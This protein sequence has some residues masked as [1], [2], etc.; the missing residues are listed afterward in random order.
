MINQGLARTAFDQL[1]L[2]AMGAA[3]GQLCARWGDARPTHVDAAMALTSTSPW[4]AMVGGVVVWTEHGAPDLSDAAGIPLG[5]PIAV[6]RIHPHSALRLQRL[7]AARFSTD[8]TTR[9]RPTPY[10]IAI[11]G[12]TP[13]P[14][15]TDVAEG[16]SLPPD[17]VV[18]GEPITEG[19][20]TFHDE[21]GLVIDPI[22]VANLLQDLLRGLPALRHTG[23][24][25]A[26]DV[27]TATPG[28]IAEVAG[29][30]IGRRLHL[31]D[32]WGRPWKDT[33]GREGVRLG[34]GSR[35]GAGPHDWDQ[36][37]SVT[38][39]SGVVRIG[40]LPDGTLATASLTP[41]ALPTATV[42][43][44]AATAPALAREFFRVAVV[45]LGLHLTGNR[46]D[47]V[48]D[49]VPGADAA[50]RSEPAPPLGSGDVEVATNGQHLLG[51]AAEIARLAGTRL[52][53]APTIADDVAVP[54]SRTE[55]WPDVPAAVGTPQD[56]TGDNTTRARADVTAAYAADTTDVVVTWPDGALP[57]ESFV[58]VFP[59]V[60]PGPAIVPLSE[61]RFSRRGD[62]GAGVV[63]GGSDFSLLVPDPF[64]VGDGTRPV[65]PTLILDLLVVT[66]GPGGVTGRLLGSITTDVAAD[67][68]APA[69]PPVTNDFDG[70]ADNA[71]GIAPAPVLG[72]PQTATPD[73]A[74]PILSALGEAAPREAPRFATMA[75]TDL[76]AAGHDGAAPGAWT[77]VVGAGFLAGRSVRGDARLGN[78]GLRAGPEDHAP[79]LRAT[80][81]L[82]QDLA[83]QA[84]RRTHHLSLRLAELNDG[85]WNPVSAV[86]GNATGAVLQSIAPTVEAPE[87]KVVPDSVVNA[88]PDDWDGLIAALAGLLPG[89]MSGLASSI[90]DPDAGDRWVEEVRRELRAV[91]AGRRDAQWAWRWALSHARRLVYVETGLF[92]ATGAGAGDHVVDLVEVLVAR[93]AAEPNLRV[94]L[95]LPRRVPFGEHYASFAQRQHLAR[96]AAIDRLVAAAPKRVVAYH[97]VGFPGRPEVVRGTFAVVDDVWA[98][99]GSSTL[100]R[101]GVTFDGG[102]DVAFMGHDLRDGVSATVR[103]MRRNAMARV[104]GIGPAPAG[105]TPDPR[106]VRLQ[107]PA[108]AF[109]LM[110]QTV[111]NGGEG[112]VQPLFR[113]LPEIELPAMP[114]DLADPEGR[115]FPDTLGG[116]PA[117]ILALGAEEF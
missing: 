83:R 12:G 15:L 79:G 108:G 62:G 52:L 39:T 97:P 35:I 18:P 110:R 21:R 109:G 88:L 28:A 78:P 42:P 26:A 102:V 98:L 85:R 44:G 47:D 8:G 87:L 115:D 67:G 48:V 40:L 50:T 27:T 101:R 41:P 20:L 2:D 105:T 6:L 77:A 63:S 73:G 43:A 57:V 92:T 4:R 96:N 114:T 22:A 113:G 74:N 7:V 37:L 71:R 65:A 66:R 36:A 17:T 72:L 59:R 75:R 60:D 56:L 90:P 64:R 31:V 45:D 89:N 95:V 10:A 100:S 11:T 93:L 24:G 51:A 54:A 38:A 46:S 76:V 5:G 25:S 58:R 13:P 32:A 84:L 107:D 103:D 53:V 55:Q 23:V 82:A 9:V 86:T 112:E 80:G 81:R 91:Q 104:L 61:L 68:V 99:A 94:V 34:T 111:D 49:G 117:A 69:D 16:A 1:G 116:L 70:V 29:M 14:E 106:F 3:S 33:S 19:T 30:A